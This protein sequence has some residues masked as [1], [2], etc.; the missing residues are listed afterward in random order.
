MS[1]QNSQDF[2]SLSSDCE[3]ERTPEYSATHFFEMLI[4]WLLSGHGGLGATAGIIARA[5]IGSILHLC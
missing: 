2:L 1:P 4:G 3:Q 5:Y